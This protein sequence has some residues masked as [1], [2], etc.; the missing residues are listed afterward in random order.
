MTYGITDVD[1][2]FVVV[3]TEIDTVLEETAISQCNRDV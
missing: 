2:E 3:H 1:I